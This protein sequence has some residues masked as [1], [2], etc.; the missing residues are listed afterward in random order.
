MSELREPWATAA[1]QAGVRQTLRG[2]AEAAKISHVTVGRL[3]NDGRTSP[4]TIVAVAE[5]LRIE[6]G[7]AYEWA[8]MASDWGPWTPPI[9]SHRLTPRA[10]AALAELILVLVGDEDD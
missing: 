2:I 6:P 5:A 9:G 8:H 7:T 1:E 4:A 10:R 3:I